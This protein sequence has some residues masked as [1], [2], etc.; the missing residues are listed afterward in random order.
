MVY[1]KYTNIRT[2]I[3]NEPMCLSYGFVTLQEH[4][5]LN[6]NSGLTPTI[7]NDVMFEEFGQIYHVSYI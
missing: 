7:F 1:S 2:N 3:F 6:P 5:Y 4:A